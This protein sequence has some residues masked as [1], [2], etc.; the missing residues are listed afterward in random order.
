MHE[1][2]TINPC[3]NIFKTLTSNI[4]RKNKPLEY[5]S[6]GL[7]LDFRR[8]CENKIQ[9]EIFEYL[10]VKYD[11][12]PKTLLRINPWNKFSTK[13]FIT[14]LKYNQILFLRILKYIESI[15]DLNIGLRNLPKVNKLNLQ[16]IRQLLI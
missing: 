14:L 3:E 1:N 9:N 6:R 12:T 8:K 10:K 13:F 11:K 16:L 7:F 15:F 4:L 5:T 2:C